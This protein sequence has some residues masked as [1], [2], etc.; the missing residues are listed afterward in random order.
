EPDNTGQ[1]EFSDR[2]CDLSVTF[3]IVHGTPP[4]LSRGEKR[5]FLLFAGSMEGMRG[6][7]GV[8]EHSTKYEPRDG[9]WTPQHTLRSHQHRR[10]SRTGTNGLGTGCRCSTSATALHRWPTTLS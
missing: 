8:I 7:R 3:G 5:W 2:D 1:G 10:G 9:S 4:L 6:R